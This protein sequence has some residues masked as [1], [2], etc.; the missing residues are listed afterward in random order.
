MSDLRRVGGEGEREAADYLVGKG[1]TIVTRNFHS[2][3]G[4]IDLVALDGDQLVCVE[5]KFRRTRGTPAEAAFDQR[6]VERL[7]A[8][9][10]DYLVAVELPERSV[11]YDLVAI[12][13]DGVRH[14][15]G[16]L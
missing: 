13:P 7:M 11:R 5:V 1:Y 2:R 14:H 12:D 3:R 9:M 8:A 16:A 4:E 15:I 10:E 6:K